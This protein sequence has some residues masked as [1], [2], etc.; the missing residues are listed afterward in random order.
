MSNLKFLKYILMVFAITSIF[1]ACKSKDV[2]DSRN[3]QL[4]TDSTAYRNNMMSDTA[5]G[6]SAVEGE[7][8]TNVTR[9]R[10]ST[11]HNTS[12][13]SKNNSTSSSNGSNTSSSGNTSTSSSTQ[14]K[15]WSKGAQGAV[16]GGAAGAVG[17][18]IISKNKGTGAAIG[19]VVG[20]AGGYIIGHEKDKKDGRIK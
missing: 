20:A 2:S 12:G 4:L 14:K 9:T 7:K 6:T 17:G 8:K 10:T 1:Y 5:T 11:T 19:A 15:G 16:I 13:S 18:A 3:I